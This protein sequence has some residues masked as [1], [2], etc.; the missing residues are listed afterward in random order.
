MR[1][2]VFGGKNILTWFYKLVR[3]V[4][5]RDFPGIAKGKALITGTFNYV[6]QTQQV[7]LMEIRIISIKRTVTIFREF[8]KPYTEFFFQQ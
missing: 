1:T 7:Y 5:C 2:N 3:E 8:I 6:G 4:K